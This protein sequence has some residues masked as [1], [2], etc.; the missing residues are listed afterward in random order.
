M[1]KMAAAGMTALFVVASPLAYAQDQSAKPQERPNA[2]EVGEP[3]DVT[4][5]RIEVLQSAL[6]L[7]PSQEKFWPAIEDA[8]RTRAQNRFARL[9]NFAGRLSEQSDSSPLEMAL[10]RNPVD[11]MHRRAEALAQRSADLKKLADAWQP[12]YEVLSPDQKRRLALVRIIA[13]RA[14]MNRIGGAGGETYD[15]DQQ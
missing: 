2:G 12:L 11:L 4:D 10:N 3:S 15:E 5:L 1:F 7:T 14:V 8:I 13:F 9:E 6:Q